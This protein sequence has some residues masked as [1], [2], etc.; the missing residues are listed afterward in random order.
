MLDTIL[1]IVILLVGIALLVITGAI[2]VAIKGGF[3]QVILGLQ[4]IYDEPGRT[5][6]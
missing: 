2:L 4:S 5:K 3:N 1:L 6:K